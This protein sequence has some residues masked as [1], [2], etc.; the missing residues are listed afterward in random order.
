[1]EQDA[2][3]LLLC[4]SF[5]YLTAGRE[6]RALALALVAES[7][8]PD[9]PGMLRML[10]HTLIENNQAARALEV[11]AKLERTEGRSPGVLLLR[12]RALHR[13]G[14]RIEARRVFRDYVDSSGIQLPVTEIV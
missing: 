1:M 10:A 9:D 13:N 5:L 2:H 3:E 6:R 11:L 14:H 12:S 7:L 8:A 4:L